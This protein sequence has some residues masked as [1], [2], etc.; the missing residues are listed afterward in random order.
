MSDKKYAKGYKNAETGE[1]FYYKDENAQTEI[2]NAKGTYGNLK[3]RLDTQYNTIN[4]TK[5]DDA[6]ISG[7]SLNLKS[8]GVTKKTLTLPSGESSSASASDIS[9][10][11]TNNNFTSTDV[12]GAL[13]ELFQNVSNGKSLV[14][15]AITDKGIST[16][17]NDTFQTMATNINKIVDNSGLIT[18]NNLLNKC[19]SKKITFGVISDIHITTD[20]TS[21]AN[22][23]LS[24]ALSFLESKCDFISA[25]G[26]FVNYDP[27]N[28]FPT[29]ATAIENCTIPIYEIAGNH[30]CG[31][32]N[33][34]TINEERWLN[35]TGNELNYEI[36]LD[37]EVFLFFS[38]RTW[39]DYYNALGKRMLEQSDMD[40]LEGKLEQYKTKPR[41]FLFHHQYLDNCEGFAYR[42]GIESNSYIDYNLDW[43]NKI[44]T[45]YKN[46]IWFSGH[47]HSP[48]SLQST[49][50]NNTV[51]NKNGEYCTMIHVPS[52]QDGSCYMVNVYDNLIEIEG[53]QD[54][55]MVN[56]AYYTVDNYVYIEEVTSV[57]LNLET[58]VF[59][60]SDSQTLTATVNPTSQQNNL[61]WTTSDPN[62][63]TVVNGVVTPVGNGDCTIIATCGSKSDTCSVSVN[64]SESELNYSIS[65][66]LNGCTSSNT[67]TSIEN[68][69]TYVTTITEGDT[70]TLES[71]TVTMGG[72]DI[73]STAYNSS[74]K[75]IGIDIVTGNIVIT[76]NV[77]YK[78]T[79]INIT[80]SA[81]TLNSTGATKQLTASLI[82]STATGTIVWSS[83]NENVAVV[84]NSG[85]VTITATA[86]GSC[87][88]TASCDGYNDSCTIN[89]YIV[90][91]TIIYSKD[92]F[93]T[94]LDSVSSRQYFE[95]T[96]DYNLPS[97]L[98]SGVKYYMTCDSFKYD[99]G[100]DV[101]MSEDKIY[102][103]GQAIN[104]SSI[105]ATKI[106]VDYENIV[107]VDT[108]L[109]NGTAGVPITKNSQVTA[110]RGFCIRSSSS[111]PASYPCTVTMLGF[112]IF[113]YG[114]TV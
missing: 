84:S 63:A 104:K 50:P 96:G 99:D 67:A 106:C 52:L 102:I 8:N 7:T 20:T 60:S 56:T 103:Y 78:V 42:N 92:T 44:I 70:V 87:T 11:D 51:Y 16:S 46:V 77:A 114:E 33:G 29:Y 66:T 19:G 5:Y 108:L 17:S 58:L 105:V 111:S 25:C 73:T 54:G 113:T 47:S 109:S 48:F 107:G 12:E 9:I 6:E 101:N 62:I 34:T 22:V 26:D 74:N 85:L 49:Y 38:Q 3:D 32:G 24:Q 43:W 41:V 2:K 53:Y 94:T 1:I 97:T 57:V 81:V 4:T 72:I 88:I 82:P 61:V 93:T 21:N 40:W 59:T 15:T 86:T 112:K 69:Q 31:V 14:A 83:D 110:L 76:V 27:D 71:V 13:N 80:D 23:K 30:D 91:R 10:T 39:K 95:I 68:G 18:C 35:I 100:T 45:T 90:K 64:I 65:S 28:E 36:D 98:Q 79:A 75:T 89:V 37:G 55:N